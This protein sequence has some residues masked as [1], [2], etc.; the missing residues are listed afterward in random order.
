MSQAKKIEDINQELLALWGEYNTAVD[1]LNVV[2]NDF[3]LPINY[4]EDIKNVLAKVKRQYN[5][6]KKKYIEIIQNKKSDINNCKSKIDQ[7]LNEAKLLLFDEYAV[8][9]NNPLLIEFD[10]SKKVK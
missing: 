4:S 9:Y 1:E 10:S 6:K 8:P 3:D 2:K 7:L 5:N